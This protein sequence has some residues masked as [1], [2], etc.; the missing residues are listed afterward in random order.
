MTEKKSNTPRTPT[1]SD[2]VKT[3]SQRILE[4]VERE[5]ESVGTSSAAR[6]GEQF[7]KHLSGLDGTPEDEDP[8]EVLGKRIGRTLGWIAVII[9][10][11]YLAITYV[12]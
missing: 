7:K 3:E 10:I 9:L 4:R 2:S 1:Q 8:I 12:F 5:S 6:S 11:I